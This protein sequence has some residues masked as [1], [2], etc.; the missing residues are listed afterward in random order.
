ME[1]LIAASIFGM[2]SVI[3]ATIF[4]NIS[5]SEKSTELSTSMYED[6]RVIM[7]NLANEIRNGTVDYEE[8][9]SIKPA[10]DGGLGA[11]YYGINRGVYASRFYDP[12]YYLKDDGTFA[13]G[14]NPKNLGTDCFKADGT[15]APSCQDPS[16]VS[17]FNLSVDKDMGKN[18]YKGTDQS[19]LKSNEQDQLYLISKDGREKIIIAKQKL[20]ADDYILSILRLNGFDKDSNGVIDIFECNLTIKSKCTDAATVLSDVKKPDNVNLTGVMI[21]PKTSDAS[22]WN[23]L[24]PFTPI[25][26]L[27]SSIKSIK[28]IIWPKEDPYR[29]FAESD[30]QYQPRITIVMTLTPSKSELAN[31]PQ[32]MPNPE[33]TLQTTVSC[34]AM[35]RIQT[36]PPTSNL[37]WIKDVPNIT[38]I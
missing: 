4:I 19:A 29:A 36:Y 8:Y 1:T 28:F 6:A 26:P 18:P 16:A 14:E 17:V 35:G 31:L 11:S 38:S 37:N 20:N 27:R 21:A 10:A 13:I 33:V 24:S 34:G 2:L 23:S 15:K 3:G 7:E 9:Y 30:V 5:H 32:D 25:S 22:T 12:G